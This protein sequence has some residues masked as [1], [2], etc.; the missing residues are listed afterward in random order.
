[1]R[2]PRK[3]SARRN[4][5]ERRK[6]L[7][8]ASRTTSAAPQPENLIWVAISE[9]MAMR[10]T[11]HKTMSVFRRY[12]IVSGSDLKDAARLLDGASTRAGTR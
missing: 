5:R 2:S 7:P 9:R 10:L 4:L 1:M 3:M 8:A 6:R 11:G 12:D